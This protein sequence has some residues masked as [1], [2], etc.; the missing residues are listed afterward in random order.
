MMKKSKSSIFLILCGALFFVF[1]RVLKADESV[2]GTFKGNGKDAKLAYAYAR[3]GEPFSGEETVMVVLTEED[4]GNNER[5]DFDAMFG[6]LG[7]ALI[8]TFQRSGDII[9]CE[10]AHSALEK[11]PFSSLG[12]MKVS[13]FKIDGDKLT[14][15][16]STGGE[17]ENFG[18]TWEADL[19]INTVIRK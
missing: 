2:T 9:G 1:P 6:K 12:S 16:V 13:D 19:S 17:V 18:E 15:K 3:P 11:S 7:S 4:P 5:P 8:L 14:A 10:V